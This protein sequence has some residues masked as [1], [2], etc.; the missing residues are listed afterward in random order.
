MRSLLHACLLAG[1]LITALL[2]AGCRSTGEGPAGATASVV[3]E[4]I[5]EVRIRVALIQAFEAERYSGKTIYGPELIFER[6]GSLGDDIMRGGWLS[7]RTVERVRVKVVPVD[8]Q[9][10]RVDC[11]AF[12]VQYPDDRVMEQEFAVRS[13]GKYKKI[14]EDVK[15]RVAAMHPPAT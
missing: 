12:T 15:R 8:P 9:K 2:G 14:L 7:G 6:R 10:F 13:S 11:N 1:T 4:A 5:D 3:V